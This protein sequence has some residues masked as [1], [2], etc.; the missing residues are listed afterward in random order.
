[1]AIYEFYPENVCS[2]VMAVELDGDLIK[3]FEVSGGCNGN[4][5]G[6]KALI[7]GQKASDIVETLSALDCGG[8]GTSCPDQLAR[9]LREALA[10]ELA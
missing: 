5:K 6:I 1:M 8:R 9:G 10:Q 3:Q 7:E 2:Q 4:L